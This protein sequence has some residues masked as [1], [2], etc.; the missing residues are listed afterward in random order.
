MNNIKEEFWIEKYRP[1]DFKD[2][3][4]QDYEKLNNLCESL[5]NIMLVSKS[6]GTGK[7]TIARIIVSKRKASTL[8]LNASDERGID[9]IRNKIKEFAMTKAHNKELKIVYLDEADGLT[10]DAQAALRTTM[11][12]HEKNCRFIITGNYINKF[13]EPLQSRC[14]LIKLSEPSKDQIR[15]RLTEIMSNENMDLSQ[16]KISEIIDKFYPDIRSMINKLQEIKIFD[17]SNTISNLASSAK[18]YQLI[19]LKD[20]QKVMDQYYSDNSDS[21]DIIRSLDELF[22]ESEF[23]KDVKL[24]ILIYLME[25]V[26]WSNITIDKDILFKGTISQIIKRLK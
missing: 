17:N 26:K 19:M 10:P 21:D 8:F 1:T 3:I 2:V 18:I 11:E 13:I 12:I 14:I 15:V 16:E 22:T 5:P 9:V 25:Y 23:P 20:I 4:G 6:P 24:D 7:S